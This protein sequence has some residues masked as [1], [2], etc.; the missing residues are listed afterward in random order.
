MG[1]FVIGF[2]CTNESPWPLPAGD[3][4]SNFDQASANVCP[5]IGYRHRHSIVRQSNREPAFF[6]LAVRRVGET[7]NSRITKNRRCQVERE[8]VFVKIG[9]SLRL[10]PFELALV[11]IQADSLLRC[12][13]RP[14]R[15]C[16]GGVLFGLGRSNANTR[17][18]EHAMFYVR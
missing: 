3:Y 9:E 2:S 18:K 5:K 8:A 17:P 6:R 7:E 1:W 10:I 15:P 16:D 14:T 11:F 13:T 12:Y 4:E